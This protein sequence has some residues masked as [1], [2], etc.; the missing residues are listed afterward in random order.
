MLSHEPLDP[1]QTPFRGG[2]KRGSITQPLGAAR[3]PTSSSGQTQGLRLP[4]PLR[5]ACGLT[6]LLRT[7][8]RLRRAHGAIGRGRRGGRWSVA[9]PCPPIIALIAWPLEPRTYECSASR[10]DGF[11]GP[12]A[13][14]RGSLN[15]G[16]SSDTRNECRASTEAPEGS[17][18]YSVNF[19]CFR[20]A[21]LRHPFRGAFLRLCYSSIACAP[22]C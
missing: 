9:C 8:L 22:T 1:G 10:I 7:R 4:P 11:W 15:L 14:G 2:V 5:A 21:F 6:A 3:G 12:A 19:T 20:H 18:D 16:R 13:H 17:T